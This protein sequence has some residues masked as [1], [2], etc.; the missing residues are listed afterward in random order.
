MGIV[1]NDVGKQPLSTVLLCA[2]GPRR[3]SIGSGHSEWVEGNSDKRLLW[4]EREKKT[5]RAIMTSFDYPD[6]GRRDSKD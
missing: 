4:G 3:V 5:Q 1:V 2:F 6:G